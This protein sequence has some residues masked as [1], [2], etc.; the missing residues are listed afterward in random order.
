MIDRITLLGLLAGMAA[1]WVYSW[2]LTRIVERHERRIQDLQ[3]WRITTDK[4]LTPREEPERMKRCGDP[5]A[6]ECRTCQR[7][8]DEGCE[9][10]YDC[11][12]CYECYGVGGC[13]E[14]R[15]ERTQ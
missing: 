12:C 4:K 6:L 5:H 1:L 15:R 9:T 2:G 13:W 11:S 14:P 8:V 10:L 3:T 7:F